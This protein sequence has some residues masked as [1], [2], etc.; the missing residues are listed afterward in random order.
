MLNSCSSPL[1]L[2]SFQMCIRTARPR[3]SSCALGLWGFF[4]KQISCFKHCYHIFGNSH[5]QKPP[6]TF[7]AEALGYFSFKPALQK[8]LVLIHLTSHKLLFSAFPGTWHIW[9]SLQTNTKSWVFP[10]H[11][12]NR[13]KALIY[14]HEAV[15]CLNPAL[16]PWEAFI[17]L[18]LRQ[19]L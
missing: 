10:S 13:I 18:K 4:L 11:R 16:A 9:Q 19:N 12:S 17:L 1:Y 3:S 14:S 5:R 2:R 15:S 8:A 6:G 7:Q